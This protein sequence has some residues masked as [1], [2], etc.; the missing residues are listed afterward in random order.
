MKRA[1]RL[2]IAITVALSV[3]ALMAMP[4]SATVLGGGEVVGTVTLT[5]PG[6]I[7]VASAPAKPTTYKFDDVVLTGAFS[8]GSTSPFAG[9][10]NVSN[11]KG[12]SPGENT[13]QGSGT[14]NSATDKAT[15]NSTDSQTAGT[16]YGTFQRVGSIVIVSLNA[17]GKIQGGAAQ[18][19]HITVAANFAPAAGQDGFVTPIC[20][21]SFTGGFGTV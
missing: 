5:N 2:S 12:G 1:T 19:F 10:I 13:I 16:F 15:F 3:V 7:P 11:V 20:S 18:S 4:A 8:D 21:A 17:N 14:V 9:P 6:C